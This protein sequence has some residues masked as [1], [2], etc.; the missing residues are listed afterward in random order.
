MLRPST[1]PRWNT[2]MTILGRV[3]RPS[4][5]AVRTRKR[6][7]EPKAST[8]MAPP[9]MNE[10]RVHSRMAPRSSP[11]LAPLELGRA[12]DERRELRHVSLL[13]NAIIVRHSSDLGAV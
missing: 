12:Q 8:A 5:Y 13:R 2:A 4:A 3:P 11:R 10:R 7:R 6:G 9:F 1:A